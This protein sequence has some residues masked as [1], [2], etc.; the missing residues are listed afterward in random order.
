M[1]A[2]IHSNYQKHHS[3]KRSSK[4]NQD[5]YLKGKNNIQLH[6]MTQQPQR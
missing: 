1:T 6:K 5:I 4:R 2:F 3:D